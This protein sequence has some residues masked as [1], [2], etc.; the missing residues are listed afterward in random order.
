MLTIDVPKSEWWN[1]ETNEFIYNEPVT[2]HLEHSLD[3]LAA[4]ESKWKVPFL[5]DRE[6]TEEETLDYIRCM[7]LDD[8]VDSLVYKNLSPQNI[9]SIQEYIKD[10][11]SATWFPSKKQ[12]NRNGEQITAELIYYWMIALN[13]PHEYSSWHLN[14]LMTLIKVCDIKNDPKKNKM[15][16]NDVLK[17][18]ATLNAARRKHRK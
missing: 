4:W 17:Q 13:I 12:G 14:R 1:E 16:K 7:T 3:S 6:K 5:T 10:P 11:M 9:E 15:S 8:N 2:L 18:N